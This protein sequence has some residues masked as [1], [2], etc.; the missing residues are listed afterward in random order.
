MILTI[1]KTIYFSYFIFIILK[2]YFFK[3]II[4]SKLFIYNLILFFYYYFIFIINY[5]FYFFL[6]VNYLKR[7]IL[8]CEWYHMRLTKCRITKFITLENTH[9][10]IIW[11][12][13]YRKMIFYNLLIKTF[14]ILITK[15]SY[16][17]KFNY[18]IIIIIIQN[19]LRLYINVIKIIKF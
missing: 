18:L 6:R 5:K 14:N 8:T 4:I 7:W 2:T 11:F 12:G 19:R 13:Y 1:L 17:N 3:N 15:P 10:V 9:Y 16:L